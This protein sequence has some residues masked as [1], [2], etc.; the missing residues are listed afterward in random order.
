MELTDAGPII[1]FAV[2][3]LA[4]FVPLA[5]GWPRWGGRIGRVV[6][7]ALQLVVLNVVV[8]ALCFTVLN[9]QYYFY[10]S[11]N[12]L[13]G[14]RASQVQLHHGGSTRQVQSAKLSGP[15]VTRVGGS[16]DYALPQP[17]ARLQT[18]TVTYPATTATAKVL[19][20]LPAGYDPTSSRNY[21]VIVGLHGFPGGP[22]SY[23]H[24]NNF[25]STAD[26]LT[27]AHQ[28]AP[29]IFVVPAINVP[30]DVDTECI[31]GPPGSP[32]AETWLAK[33]L[34]AWVVRHLHVRTDRT[35]WV[36]MGFSYGAW[37][38]AFLTMEHPETFA[39]A[40]V[41]LGYFRPEFATDYAPYSPAQLR[42]YDLVKLAETSPPPVA[43]WVFSSR[44]DA[45]SYP[46]TSRFLSHVKAPLDVSATIVATGG[47]RASVYEPFTTSALTWLSK[48]FPHF[49]A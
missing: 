49:R 10:S 28:L 4:L 14:A 33:D 41:F 22:L 27:A 35:S 23:S 16:R 17:G 19:V 32:Q 7:R 34:P 2:L 30:A 46:T 18:Y 1:V 15:G 13:F 48:T 39:G 38:A 26:Q 6:V 8:I 11:W 31:N 42:K 3:A 37:C 44:Q 40:I 29:S 21:P 9:D 20:Y 5:F 24:A 36:A 43:M 45:S 12:D 25:F 47:H